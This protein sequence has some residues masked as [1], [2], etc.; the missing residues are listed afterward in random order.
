MCINLLF[1]KFS[2]TH[3]GDDLQPR[4]VGPLDCAAKRPRLLEQ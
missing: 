1:D 3:A 2:N 4:A